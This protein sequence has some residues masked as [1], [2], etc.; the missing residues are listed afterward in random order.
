MWITVYL[1]ILYLFIESKNQTSISKGNTAAIFVSVYI[2]TYATGISI[3]GIV[4]LIFAFILNKKM[5]NDNKPIEYNGE[6]RNGT[7]PP[8]NNLVNI[9][10]LT[11]SLAKWHKFTR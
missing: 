5:N 3:Y 9:W 7:H 11:C 4:R 2:I 8:Y 10:K 1:G 6:V